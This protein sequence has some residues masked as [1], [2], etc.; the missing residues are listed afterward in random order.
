MPPRKLRWHTRRKSLRRPK[1][2]KRK[3]ITK[4]RS[5][6]KTAMKDLGYAKKGKPMV[7]KA[8]KK[9]TMKKMGKKAC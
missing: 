4:K 3:C 8:A 7:K 5:K 9:A 2:A 1:L 6:M